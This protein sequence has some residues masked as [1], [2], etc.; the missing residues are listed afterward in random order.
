MFEII[1][2]LV[3][4]LVTFLLI[5]I[6]SIKVVFILNFETLNFIT[7]NILSLKYML[8]IYYLLKFKKNQFKI[9]TLIN[10]N[11]K[12]NTIIQLYITKLRFKIW[13][14][15]IRTQKINSFI[16]KIFNI[17]LASFQVED[18]FEKV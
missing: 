15:N 9:K 16:F 12:V 2:K 17:I 8:Y 1:K 14:I 11:N 7:K 6:A 13:P 18:K 5:T 10:S 4:I 3:L